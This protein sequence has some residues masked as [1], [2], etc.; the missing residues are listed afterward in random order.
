M[1]I[2]PEIL[3]MEQ[4]A[5]Y[6]Q[7]STRTL[8]RMVADGRAPGR[9]V[10]SQWRFDREQLREWVRGEPSSPAEREQAGR[11]LSQRELVEKESLR[12]GV[13][14]PETLLDMQQDYAERRRQDDEAAKA[15]VDPD[16][17]DR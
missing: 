15:T 9:Q 3:T 4:A 1:S 13:D 8:Q 16:S 5:D 11:A 12:L 10:G 14:V 2:Y 7:V 17:D 6:L